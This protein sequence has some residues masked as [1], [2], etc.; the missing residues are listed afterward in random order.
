MQ[1]KQFSSVEKF[2][3]DQQE[4]INRLIYEQEYRRRE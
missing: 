4:P 1:I 2:E 3:N